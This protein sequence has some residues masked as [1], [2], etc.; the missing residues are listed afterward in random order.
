[1]PE[2]RVE[3]REKEEEVEDEEEGAGMRTSFELRRG[4]AGHRG[5]RGRGRRREPGQSWIHMMGTA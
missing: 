4:L 3:E 5:A 2:G 1:V